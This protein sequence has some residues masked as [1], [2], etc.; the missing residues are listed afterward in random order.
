MQLASSIRYGG[1]LVNAADC[2]Y[3]DYRKLG[4]TCPHCHESVF[5]VQG[6]ERH[7]QKTSKTTEVTAH[8]NHRPD[9]SEDAIALCELRSRQITS[10]EIQ[11]RETKSKNQR[12][13]LFNRYLWSILS[14]C[15]KLKK[16]EQKQ[17]SVNNGFKNICKSAEI[18]ERVLKDYKNF[19][20]QAIS[21]YKNKIIS[22]ADFF[23]TDLMKKV[24]ND[25]LVFQEELK[26]TLILWRQQ[27]DAKM[28]VEIYKEAVSCLLQRKHLPILE[29]LIV[30][31]IDNFVLS[32]FCL[33]V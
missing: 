19:F 13:Q 8:F 1:L 9:K 32:T 21:S 11:K 5:L 23:I 29:K 24:S 22:E 2:N 10:A 20:I 14:T 7:Y 18:K 3:D 17:H 16:F 12:L 31:S 28:Q 26:G 4:L 27:I 33:E 30:A 6:H 15:Y 25:K